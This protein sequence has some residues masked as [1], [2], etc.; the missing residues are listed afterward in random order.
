MLFFGL[1]LLTSTRAKSAPLQLNVKLL[2]SYSKLSLPQASPEATFCS[3]ILKPPYLFFSYTFYT[4]QKNLLDSVLPDS[5]SKG[6]HP[7]YCQVVELCGW[8]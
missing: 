2:M 8:A 6:K 5:Y 4:S 3:S 1:K 7:N